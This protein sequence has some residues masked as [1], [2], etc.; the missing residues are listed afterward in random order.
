MQALQEFRGARK[1]LRPKRST[2]FFAPLPSESLSGLY[3]ATS[4]PSRFLCFTK[5]DERGA[6]IVETHA[7]A[8]RH[9]HRGKFFHSDDIDIEVENEFA[10]LRVHLR[11]RIV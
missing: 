2:S 7:A 11:K 10:R 5:L 9:V 8:A 1:A 4:S 6:H 3:C